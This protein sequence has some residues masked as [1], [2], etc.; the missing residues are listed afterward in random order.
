MGKKRPIIYNPITAEEYRKE[1]ETT[2]STGI[3]NP[4]ADP[5]ITV[6][7]Q[8][9][10]DDLDPTDVGAFQYFLATKMWGFQGGRSLLEGG[11]ETTI[12]T[13]HYAPDQLLLKAMG[14]ADNFFSQT[15][16][17]DV[18][19]WLM[20]SRFSSPSEREGMYEILRS[21]QAG[22]FQYETR[23]VPAPGGRGGEVTEW[24][25]PFTGQWSSQPPEG[26]DTASFDSF[27]QTA[28]VNELSHRSVAAIEFLMSQVDRLG[29]EGDIISSYDYESVLTPNQIKQL[30]DAVLNARQDTTGVDAVLQRFTPFS[31]EE[32]KGSIVR[33][34][35][36]SNT[37]EVSEDFLRA[38]P[39]KGLAVVKFLEE[40]HPGAEIRVGG[41]G[42]VHPVSEMLGRP[43][44][45]VLGGP[46]IAYKWAARGY[47][48]ASELATYGAPGS[49]RRDEAAQEADRIRADLQK[50]VIPP[51]QVDQALRD[52]ARLEDESIA[53]NVMNEGESFESDIH[54]AFMPERAGYGIA[55][56]SA[57]GIGL[58]PGDPGYDEWT[59]TMMLISNF[60]AAD[61]LG[62][63][64][65]ISKG[66]KATR[67]AT[68]GAVATVER[69]AANAADMERAIESGTSATR[70]LS[71]TQWVRVGTDARNASEAEQGILLAEAR[72]AARAKGYDVVDVT[73]ADGGRDIL[74][75]GM[76]AEE[77]IQ[78]SRG[79]GQDSF[80][81]ADGIVH[82]DRT[83]T[84]VDWAKADDVT[85]VHEVG[86]DIINAPNRTSAFRMDVPDEA[87]RMKLAP[88]TISRNWI[89]QKIFEANAKTPDE[90]LNNE[91]VGG[92]AQRIFH[93]VDKA[94]NL[95]TKVYYAEQARLGT[96]AT[97]EAA[98]RAGVERAFGAVGSWM[99]NADP[100]VLRA[101][102]DARDPADVV[103]ILQA[104]IQGGI[105]NPLHV[106]TLMHRQGTIA[107]RLGEIDNELAQ[108]S[109]LESELAEFA[110]RAG[111]TDR[112]TTD[113]SRL[114]DFSNSGQGGAL[115]DLIKQWQEARGKLAALDNERIGLLSERY[116]IQ[117]QLDL[118]D[119]V[120]PIRELPSDKL[121]DELIAVVKA[122]ERDEI[123]DMLVELGRE[124]ML[125]SKAS[126]ERAAG[127]VDDLTAK[128]V[129]R[130]ASK[131]QIARV[132]KQVER[133]RNGK[134]R[135]VFRVWRN[136]NTHLTGG[137]EL[138]M[139]TSRAGLAEDQLADFTIKTVTT[140]RDRAKL[141]GLQQVDIEDLISSYLRVS[142]RQDWYRW[143][144]RFFS[145]IA[146]KSP[147][148]D[149]RSRGEMRNFAHSLFSE[150]GGGYLAEVGSDGVA[151]QRHTLSRIVID[152]V[153]GTKLSSGVPMFTGDWLDAVRLPSNEFDAAH[154]SRV[155]R[156]QERALETSGMQEKA[157]QALM[158]VRDVINASTYIWKSAVLMGRMPFALLSRIQGEQAF[159]MAA[160][161]YASGV[162]HPLEWIRSM[163][164]RGE[165]ARFADNH[166][167]FLG[168]LVNNYNDV[169]SFGSKARV[170]RRSKATLS[171]IDGKRYWNALSAMFLRR[172]RSTEVAF[173]LDHNPQEI[174]EWLRSP[175]SG[176]KGDGILDNI[177][178]TKPADYAGSTDAYILEQ[179]SRGKQELDDLIG[180]NPTL[181]AALK[182]GSTPHQYEVDH[183]YYTETNGEYM[184][185]DEKRFWMQIDGQQGEYMRLA[186]AK[187]GELYVDYVE[188]PPALRGKGLGKNLYAQAQAEALRRGTKLT[189]GVTVSPEAR[190]VWE[191]L[192][193]EGKARQVPAR[194]KKT[195]GE[196]EYI[197]D[198]LA[199]TGK[200]TVG[201]SFSVGTEQFADELARL[202][203][204]G[205][206]MP[207]QF[208]NGNAVESVIADKQHLAARFRDFMFKQFYSRPD[209]YLSRGPMFRQAAAREYDRLRGLGWG[210]KRAESA[211]TAWAA[212]QTSGWMYDLASRTSGQYFLRNVM[213]FFPAFQE[214]GGVWLKRLPTQRGGGGFAGWATG[215]AFFAHKAD[216]LLSFFED[217]GMVQ[218]DANGEYSF[219]IPQL[220][221]AWRALTGDQGA[222]L[223]FRAESITGM[224]PFPKFNDGK[225]DLTS[226]IPGLGPMPSQILGAMADHNEVIDDLTDF[227]LPYGDEPRLGPTSINNMFYAA[228]VVP[229][230][231][232][233]TA[234][235]Q[236]LMI[237]MA[238]EDGL[239]SAMMDAPEFDESWSPAR[240]RAWSEDLIARAEKRAGAGFLLRAAVSML[241][242]VSVDVTS[243]HAE[244]MNTIWKFVE[245][246]QEAGGDSPAS[247][248]IEGFKSEYP[249]AVWYTNG[250]SINH[251]QGREV[252]G[253]DDWIK[254]WER[255]NI[256]VLSPKEF[257][258]WNMGM[259]QYWNTLGRAYQP[260]E[261]AT[262]PE[263]LLTGF[264]RRVAKNDAYAQF[265]RYLN[266][267]PVFDSLF[268]EWKAARDERKGGVSMTALQTELADARTALSTVSEAFTTAGIRD[269]DYMSVIGRLQE[270]I[271]YIA[272][273]SDDPAWRNVNWWYKNVGTPASEEL[274]QLYDAAFA[275][276]KPEQGPIFEKIRQLK[277]TLLPVQKDGVTYPA[278]EEV[279][280]SN[281]SSEEQALRRMEWASSP[282]E[283]L[284]NF[285]LIQAGY[286]DDPLWDEMATLIN[287]TEAQVRQIAA[288]NYWSTSSTEY[289]ELQQRALLAQVKWAEENGML[290]ELKLAKS[291]PFERVLYT[292]AY[293]GNRTFE[294]VATE[295]RRVQAMFEAEGLSLG[296]S[297]SA[298]RRA[299][300]YLF[301]YID[302]A[303]A[304]DDSF[305]N[306]MEQ[307]EQ[308]FAAPGRER[309]V[310]Y[311]MYFKLW[312]DYFGPTPLINY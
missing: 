23:Q 233:F 257:I 113:I 308:V 126:V 9:N 288:D 41:Q 127:L 281:K 20:A 79:L 30:E 161:D 151:T 240:K 129:A 119:I 97:V 14:E 311:E 285:E 293:Q 224:L 26:S 164:A 302:S 185:G 292:G 263:I 124:S 15:F 33:V 108:L 35:R 167:D 112:L 202:H 246:Y 90:L 198:E 278:P 133:T 45:F 269:E 61:P 115:R 98:K 276:P 264:E 125:T 85:D 88:P 210:E 310:G 235:T 250:R 34:E 173:Y 237:T 303:R 193:K 239:R 81:T 181:K 252:E 214:L 94:R 120:I 251:T 297:S 71:D 234:D 16:G 162:N 199:A 178:S 165:F 87:V 305:E 219:G 137:A 277:N 150:R 259:T 183:T 194:A 228:G 130:G 177:L 13:V 207:P 92:I 282:V 29:D 231:E 122:S 82:T 77:G 109:R 166:A 262:A 12:A 54:D 136:V 171:P 291:A 116:T 187:N 135:Q 62:L 197:A 47:G 21:M 117:S 222:Q 107:A 309:A 65:A 8:R 304:S 172:Y 123:E 134:A 307:Y 24:K 22:T 66:L 148:L 256:H 84:P 138:V 50:G 182:R 203:K 131:K 144:D 244:A 73:R 212:E 152:P 7:G 226:L 186:R 175:L 147:Y 38:H 274:S 70:Y 27:I 99:I 196:Y 169:N 75:L 5:E 4:A 158:G 121:V 312:L 189:S 52:I 267:H 11:P 59:T 243:E 56:M 142:N 283:W 229:P 32:F 300:E 174:M 209:V 93:E 96:D 275:L 39:V 160:L 67:S 284:S 204:A 106:G 74:I 37:Y 218:R 247:T 86:V 280:W 295:V 215:S 225:I 253:Y 188:I 232:Y 248:L 110:A 78:L 145:D 57:D 72:T 191:S 286:G 290:D 100:R 114:R 179:I 238:V 143:V 146:E 155:R 149:A 236:N 261:G 111:V 241:S 170:L 260:T 216:A 31:S 211:A 230:W 48:E 268:T 271:N 55:E 46:A 273:R 118:D 220:D 1:T 40:N 83:I 195:Y 10:I 89:T 299:Q 301:G 245:N 104:G 294:A 68:T 298:A 139:P 296:G 213:P 18:A 200:E 272:E 192:V 289:Q 153:T 105:T 156:W 103:T 43:V 60:S 140:I 157:A 258:E 28:G 132:L 221:S 95:G 102:A 25:D 3:Y 76:D 201:T 53:G 190:R 69:V 227:I 176:E 51:D 58:Y 6:P 254:E 270:K 44:D 205:E 2:P 36:G 217:L 163:K 42:L 265:D 249:D 266:S 17:A 19:P 287:R 206:Y 63:P 208:V 223:R 128:L 91:T 180:E 255:G 242:P 80:R 49:E 168:T 159:R 141:Y 154:L 306:L 279:W 101:L 184:L 64:G